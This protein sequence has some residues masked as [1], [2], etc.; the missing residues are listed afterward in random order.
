MRRNKMKNPYDKNVDDLIATISKAIEEADLKKE[1]TPELVNCIE[2]SATAFM[3]GVTKR[4]ASTNCNI[5]DKNINTISE[6][7]IKAGVD[8]VE[9]KL[10]EKMIEKNS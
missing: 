4:L 9:K 7:H 5:S 8:Y 2:L 3:F 6:L 10:I 1:F